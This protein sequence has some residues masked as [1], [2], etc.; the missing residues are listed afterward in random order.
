VEAISP[1]CRESIET[2]PDGLAVVTRDASFGTDFKVTLL[3][4][5]GR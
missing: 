1:F 2:G 3:G 5:C 4:A